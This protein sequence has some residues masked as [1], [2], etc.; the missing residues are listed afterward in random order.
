MDWEELAEKLLVKAYIDVGLTPPQWI[1]S[2]V[3]EEEDFYDKMIEDVRGFMLESINNAYARFIRSTGEESDRERINSV[4]ERP[5][6]PWL[7]V[8]GEELLITTRILS[9]LQDVIGDIGG[10]KS[11]AELLGWEYIPKYSLKEKGKVRNMSVIRTTKEDFI[12]FL[13]LS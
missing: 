5:L 10:L 8:R 11:L 7:I 9:E 4:L 2:K 13:L 1:S 12:D 6:I 3:S